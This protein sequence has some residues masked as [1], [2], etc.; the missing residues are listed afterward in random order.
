MDTE[1]EPQL[2]QPRVREGSRWKSAKTTKWGNSVR[3]AAG[4]CMLTRSGRGSATGPGGRLR[5]QGFVGSTINGLR[6]ANAC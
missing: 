2:P 3:I 5:R 1:V 4:E 6:Q